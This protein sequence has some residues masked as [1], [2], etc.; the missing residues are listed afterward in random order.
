[1]RLLFFWLFVSSCSLNQNRSL[2]KNSPLSEKIV[3]ALARLKCPQ[4]I[5][6]HQIQGLNYLQL[7]P[8]VQ[9][10]VK[11]AIETREEMG[12]SLRAYSESQFAKERTTPQDVEAATAVRSA[13]EYLGGVATHFQKKRE[14]RSAHSRVPT[15]G[16]WTA[17]TVGPQVDQTLIEY[18]HRYAGSS[19][20]EAKDKEQEAKN[21]EAEVLLQLFLVVT[22]NNL[23]RSR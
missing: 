2:P 9:W 5:E 8:V 22:S 10:L 16:R 14:L 23:W 13:S 4:P 19:V 6:P 18:G 11:K 20:P 12:D 15:R 1:M 7:F 3:R 17:E 21:K